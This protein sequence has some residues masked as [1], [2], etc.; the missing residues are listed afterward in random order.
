[1]TFSEYLIQFDEDLTCL[2]E[3]MHE[4][5]NSDVRLV[6][7]MKKADYLTGGKQLRAI[8]A[9]LAARLCGIESR[10]GHRAAVAIEFIHT[11]TLLHDDVVDEA[12]MRRHLPA[13][14]KVYGN[15]A[16]V[17]A[18][19]FLYSRASQ[20]LAQL[21]NIALLQRVA[22]ATNKLAEGELL[23]LLNRGKPDMNEKTYYAIIERKTANLFSVASAAAALLAQQDD[24]ALS[25]YGYHLGI[26]FQLVDDCLDYEG[27]DADLGKRTG[28]DFNEGKMTLPVILMLTR[29]A[30][31]RRSSLISDWRDNTPADFS[32][33]SALLRSSGALADVRGLAQERVALAVAALSP[34]PDGGI[35][36]AL[37]RLAQESVQRDR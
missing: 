2:R 37:V 16:A 9:V 20:M 11:A 14:A 30:E 25:D 10:T 26:A 8:V 15:A 3:V 7:D 29:I 19:D 1:M 23:Q 17:L 24:K 27:A 31:T 35:K 28:A 12:P 21:D 33:I 34:Y 18:G 36:T 4:H 13:A 5:L 22:D 32:E 6:G